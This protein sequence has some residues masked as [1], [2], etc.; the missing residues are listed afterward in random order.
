MTSELGLSL[1]DLLQHAQ[2]GDAAELDRLFAACRNYLCVLAQSHIEG[3]LKAKADASDLVQQT[4]LEAHRDFAQFRGGSEKEWLAW[5]RQIL[6]H[7]AAEF[8]RHYRGTDKRR[9]GLEVAMQPASDGV[10]HPGREPSDPGESP[11][12][13]LI[14]KEHEVLIA[15]AL[16]Q[17]PADYREVIDLRNLQ[18][19]PFAEVAVRMGRSRPAVQMLWMRALRKLHDILAVLQQGSSI[20]SNGSG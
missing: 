15:D 19:L 17:L 10:A 7:N 5:L 12:Q 9:V 11:S 6:A 2:A 3:R 1:S 20:A 16:V 4:L 18:R 8:A 14:R 13:Q